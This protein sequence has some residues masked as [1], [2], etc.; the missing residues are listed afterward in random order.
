MEGAEPAWVR[1]LNRLYFSSWMIMTRRKE[2][3][4]W[5]T[6]AFSGLENRGALM[7]LNTTLRE[8]KTL[9]KREQLL[10]LNPCVGRFMSR[11]GLRMWSSRT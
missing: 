1:V 7:G 11:F 8:S 9:M 6:E 3:K 2:P 5:A 4:K 10:A